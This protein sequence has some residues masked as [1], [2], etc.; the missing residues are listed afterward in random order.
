M[1]F[2]EVEVNISS[3]QSNLILSLSPYL[4]HNLTPPR[5]FGARL[6]IQTAR[7]LKTNTSC[8]RSKRKGGGIGFY[9]TENLQ[10]DIDSPF[11][12]EGQ[13]HLCIELKFGKA[14]KL[15][16]YN[17][18]RLPDAIPAELL[19]RNPDIPSSSS[20]HLIVVDDF[21]VDISDQLKRLLLAKLAIAR[22]QNSSLH[23]PRFTLPVCHPPFAPVEGEN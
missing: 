19:Q 14:K 21:N 18:Y 8:T 22:V 10:Y 16:I 13:R 4:I 20:H 6:S 12:K 23:L 3:V 17:V 5:G 15:Q 9:L 1:S 11:Q 7:L 2:Q